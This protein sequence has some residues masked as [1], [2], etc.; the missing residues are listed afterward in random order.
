MNKL[1][2]QHLMIGF[3]LIILALLIYLIISPCREHLDPIEGSL[4]VEETEK[5]LIEI[6]KKYPHYDL[7]VAGVTVSP[8][9]TVLDEKEM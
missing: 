5:Q 2:S 7:A 8:K 3:A 1:T 4:S 6:R 9:I